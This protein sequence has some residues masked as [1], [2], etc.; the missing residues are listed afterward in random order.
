MSF[1]RHLLKRMKG[2][3]EL[4]YIQLDYIESTGT[5]YIDTGYI[6]TINTDIKTRASVQYNSGSTP[7]ALFGY[8][9]GNDPYNRYAVQYHKEV[10]YVAKGKTEGVISTIDYTKMCDIETKGSKY[11]YDGNVISVAPLDFSVSNK[12]SIVLFARRTTNVNRHSKSKIEFF[13]IYEKGAL[14]MD[15]IPCIRKTD[16]VVCM[17]DNVSQSFF[18][19]EGTG[20][21]VPGTLTNLPEGYAQVSYLESTGTQYIDIGLKV[22]N[23]TKVE[24]VG[25]QYTSNSSLFGVNPLFV[26][27]SSQ[28]NDKKQLCR[29]RYNNTTQDTNVNILKLSKIVF[30][31]NKGYIN[32]VLLAT[33]TEATFSSTYNAILFGRR[34]NGSGTLEEL[35][36]Q[37]IDYFK[38]W[39]NDVLVR[40]MI[41]CLDNEGVPCMYDILNNKC[42]Y[43][44]G[45]GDFVY[46]EIIKR[47]GF[48]KGYQELEYLQAIDGNYIFIPVTVK[49]TDVFKMKVKPLATNASFV[50]GITYGSYTSGVQLRYQS[51]AWQGRWGGNAWLNYKTAPINEI[52]EIV[53]KNGE[54]IINGETIPF[55]K[56][57]SGI[58]GTG[59]L[60][61]FA[62]QYNNK[63]E[64][65]TGEMQ[66][67]SFQMNDDINLVP[68][69]DENGRPCM[70]D[71]VNYKTYY[72]LGE[73]EFLYGIK[74][75]T[76]NLIKETNLGFPSG[77]NTSISINSTYPYSYYMNDILLEVGKTYEVNVAYVRTPSSTDDGTIRLRML[78]EDGTF[79]GAPSSGT[80]TSFFES[81]EL[82][83]KVGPSAISPWF[84]F[85]KAILKP[86]KN[87]Y[88]RPLVILGTKAKTP[89]CA[90]FVD[91]KEV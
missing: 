76:K 57:T 58:E 70:Y 6:P 14:V 81:V 66:I 63:P 33:F 11:I 85:Q 8:L 10:V 32:D 27:T 38:M 65:N 40:D 25:K 74:E 3:K 47:T 61:I 26:I 80:Y 44:E 50:M 20:S 1:R 83:G 31:K 19:N 46:G 29:F 75:P 56:A 49:S 36:Q 54:I 67:M 88:M 78:N 24:L 37:R 55:T 30:D 86:K 18:E 69:L 2:E 45:T 16:G 79:W 12:L 9:S 48:P 72:N 35:A 21:F 41:P 7:V 73:G 22:S 60:G 89:P 91:I 52:Y 71:I 13:K 84:S 77:N 87:C 23:K 17:Y 5:Q 82:T 64:L 59:N 43:N 28:S 4:P 62:R 34:I 51:G 39:E 53:Y 42:Y 90:Y 15:L 68:A